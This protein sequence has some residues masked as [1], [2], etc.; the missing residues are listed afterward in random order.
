M[1]FMLNHVKVSI[2]ER[3]FVLMRSIFDFTIVHII[4]L[5]WFHHFTH[6]IQIVGRVLSE[7]KNILYELDLLSMIVAVQ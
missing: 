3:N 7:L 5:G 4:V 6:P 1:M 2:Y